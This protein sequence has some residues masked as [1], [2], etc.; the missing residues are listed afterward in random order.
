MRKRTL[1]IMLLS[2]CLIAASVFTVWG[3]R[4]NTISQIFNH[5][6]EALT[7]ID[8]LENALIEWSEPGKCWFTHGFKTDYSMDICYKGLWYFDISFHVGSMQQRLNCC[9]SGNHSCRPFAGDMEGAACAYFGKGKTFWD[10][11]IQL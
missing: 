4:N 5:D 3:N 1:K 8:G 11:I 6:V 9:E 7:N 10:G 2:I